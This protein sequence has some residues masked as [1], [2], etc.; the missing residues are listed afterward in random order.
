[1]VAGIAALVRSV[2]PQLTARQVMHRI[3]DTA[4]HPAAEWDPWVGHGVVDALAAV[5]TDGV[6]ADKPK[7]PAL[8]AG[9]PVAAPAHD[10]ASRRISLV[11]AAACVAAATA[12]MTLSA[13]WLRRRTESVA[14]D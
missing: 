10:T 11:G 5:S 8:V 13:S 9:A 1:V 4:H 14:D 12:A 3:E 7:P 2:A 6:G